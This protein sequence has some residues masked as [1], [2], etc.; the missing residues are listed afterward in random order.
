MYSA[1][2]LCCSI[3]WYS[4]HANPNDPSV[5]VST[6]NSMAV[7]SNPDA[8][9]SHAAVKP[10]LHLLAIEFHIISTLSGGAKMSLERQGQH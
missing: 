2:R 3:A 6:C 8:F 7:H 4:C 5:S 9:D 10:E 1:M